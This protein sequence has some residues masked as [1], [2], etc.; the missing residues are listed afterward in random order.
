MLLLWSRVSFDP[1]LGVLCC[2]TLTSSIRHFC[3]VSIML[4]GDRTSRQL[5]PQMSSLYRS[6][7][8]SR[9]TSRRVPTVHIATHV[10]TDREW[11]GTNE[12]AK[13][14]RLVVFKYKRCRGYVIVHALLCTSQN[15]FG[16]HSEAW[17]V[18]ENSINVS[19]KTKP[20]TQS[21]ATRSS[22]C[23]EFPALL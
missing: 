3:R 19:N 4:L 6:S 9:S 10:H 5:W 13:Q 7:D 1:V 21:L 20:V 14:T 11:I 18:Q 22:C 16:V 12:L 15:R 8:V 23:R 2:A 17:T